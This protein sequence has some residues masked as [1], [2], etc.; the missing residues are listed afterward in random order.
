EV[1]VN[2]V[3]V[4]GSKLIASKIDIIT[5]SACMLRDMIS[6]RLSYTFGLWKI[7]SHGGLSSA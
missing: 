6:V 3:E 5:T 7:A 4:P 2:W 1:A